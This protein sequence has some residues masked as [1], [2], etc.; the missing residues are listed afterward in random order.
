MRTFQ[1]IFL[2]LTTIMLS[3]SASADTLYLKDG[4]TF[5]GVVK[6]ETRTAVVFEVMISGIR[7]EMTFRKNEVDRIEKGAVAP[8]PAPTN[9]GGP[10]GEERS[11]SSAPA[12]SKPATTSDRV[13][14]LVV[15]IHGTF[16]EDVAPAGVVDALAFATRRG[17]PHVVFDIDSPGGYSW[18]AREITDA[19]EASAPALTYTAFIKDGFSAACWVALSCD[20][21]FMAPG[22]SMGAAVGYTHDNSTGEIAVDAKFNSASAAHLAS[23]AQSHGH[24][25]AMARA[26]I[27]LE[28]E[29]FAV[30]TA[31]GEWE[32]MAERPSG[33]GLTID[34]L[35]TKT[36]ILTLT[37]EE[38][39]KYGVAAIARSE[40]ELGATLGI[41][42]WTK[43]NNYGEAAMRK[44][45]A[46]LARGEGNPVMMMDRLGALAAVING[47]FEEAQSTAPEH[48]QITHHQESGLM[49]QQSQDEWKRRCDETLNVLTRTMKQVEEYADLQEKLE[50]MGIDPPTHDLHIQD[51][52]SDVNK[53][54]AWLRA[55]RNKRYYP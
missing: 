44:A 12:R 4:R 1:R 38:A 47:G 35:A 28:N 14:Y 15:P 10:K 39:A 53:R 30:E 8:S 6:Q 50:E 43:F 27:I 41:D 54:I 26:F 48:T 51:I 17:I 5:E 13:N 20:R 3:A 52:R 40:E 33:A 19:M 7:S 23:I 11:R 2:V 31:P 21:I 36:S 25:A 34:T 37:A 42:G 46:A 9:T 29:C 49:T 55:N 16:G 22:S 45:G 32:I 18:A 24:S